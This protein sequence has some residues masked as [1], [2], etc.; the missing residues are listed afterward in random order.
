MPIG[1]LNSPEFIHNLRDFIH[2]VA[3]V[4]ATAKYKNL[5]V[6]SML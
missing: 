2:E 4:K 3:R 1:Q 6:Q 5:I